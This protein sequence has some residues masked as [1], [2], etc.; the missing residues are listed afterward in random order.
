MGIRT[1]CSCDKCKTVVESATQ[2]RRITLSIEP[3][4]KYE[5]SPG[6]AYAIGTAPHSPAPP[7][8]TWLFPGRA[9]VL[10]NP[11]LYDTLKDRR[12]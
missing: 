2:L 10:T 4:A 1:I 12:L 7:L 11:M 8:G 6:N 5:Y 9:C 3:S